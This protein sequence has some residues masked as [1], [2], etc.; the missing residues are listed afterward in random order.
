MNDMGLTLPGWHVL[1]FEDGKLL[2]MCHISLEDVKK[3]LVKH[4]K[5]TD[6][7]MCKNTR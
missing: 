7:N 2:D 6:W 1:R 5:E 3:F 4:A